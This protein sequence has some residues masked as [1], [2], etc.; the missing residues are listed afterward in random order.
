MLPAAGGGLHAAAGVGENA[1]ARRAR[2]F[3]ATSIPADSVPARLCSPGS[4]LAGRR[5]M[6][7]TGDSGSF[8]QIS[9][10]VGD[11]RLG[12]NSPWHGNHQPF[13]PPD[14][15]PDGR[16]RILKRAFSLS[17]ST[18]KKSWQ[19][20][21]EPTLMSPFPQLSDQSRLSRIEETAGFRRLENL[22]RAVKTTN[23]Q[24]GGA[25]PTRQG[26]GGRAVD[27][28][29]RRVLNVSNKLVS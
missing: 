28:L 14:G 22:A 6:C 16:I 12:R 4:H 26:G 24:T 15:P 19:E 9:S 17:I 29:W 13:I 23:A 5:T 3:P 2:R 10:I 18:Q 1:G 11:Y 7:C 21:A 27:W 20:M 25:S 8:W